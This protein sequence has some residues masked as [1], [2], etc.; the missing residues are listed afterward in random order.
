[1]GES[2]KVNLH[3]LNPTMLK[4]KDLQDMLQLQTI[5]VDHLESK[6]VLQPL[7][8]KEFEYVFSDNGFIMGLYHEQKLIA[9]RVMLVPPIDNE[10]LGIDAGIPTSELSRVIYQELSIVHPDYRGKGLQKQM[11][12]FVMA[13]VDQSRFDYIC[14]TVAPFNIASLKDKFAL[15]LH[16]VALKLK[17]EGKLRY[18]LMNKV[19]DGQKVEGH[20][21]ERFIPMSDIL[22]QQQA[23][24]EGFVG[25]NMRFQTEWVVQYRKSE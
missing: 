4:H 7:T 19:H 6:D 2:I 15:G 22:I 25:V 21:E 23:L 11:G 18:V 14:A 3:K 24:E 16:I 9:F 20:A 5:A 8:I 12:E 1:M 13:R 17:Y 10:H